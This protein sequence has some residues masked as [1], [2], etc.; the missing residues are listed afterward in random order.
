MRVEVTAIPNVPDIQ[1]GDDLATV[2]GDCLA[3]AG[4]VQTGD[5]LCLAHKIVS[6]AE[7][8]VVDLTTVSPSEE[9]MRLAETLN[10]DPAKIEVILG[11]SDHVVKSWK[12]P[13]QSEGTI[14][15]KHRLGFTSANA[16]VDESNIAGERSVITLPDDPDASAADLG[17]TLEAR[18]GIRLGVVI[19]D[20]FGRP[21]RLGQVNVAIG[22][23]QVPAKLSQIGEVDAWGRPLSVTEPALGDELAAAS[24]LV[25]T[26]AGKTPLVVFRGVDWTPDASACAQHLVRASREDMFQ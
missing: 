8:N 14:I 18:F 6:K 3:N 11:Q 4:G 21:W 5:I 9:A 19:T 7:G 23:Y 1:P 13:D 17:R 24:G 22:L 15:C 10:K 25:V 16:G 26:K 12:R 2:L 20:T